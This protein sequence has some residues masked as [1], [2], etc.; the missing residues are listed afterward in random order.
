M[1]AVMGI[2]ADELRKKLKDE[3]YPEIDIANYNTPK[4]VV[5][6]GPLTTIN[7]MVK[8]FG[9]QGITVVPLNVSAFNQWVK[10]TQLE[11]WRNRHA[12]QIGIKIMEEAASLLKERLRTI[13][14]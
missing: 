11:N 8:D 1:A 4:Q 7:N 14:L 12:D 5:V 6:S 10:G 3:G 2:A 13:D 9:K